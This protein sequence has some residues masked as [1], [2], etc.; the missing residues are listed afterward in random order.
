MSRR[1]S[2]ASV[3][4]LL[5]IACCVQAQTTTQK[6]ATASISGKVTIKG[7][8]AVGVVIMATPADDYRRPSVQKPH[9]ARTDQT[10]RYRIT[11]LPA[12]SYTITPVAP[13]LVLVQQSESVVLSEGEEVEDINL[14]LA[15]GGV[16]TG[17]V[18]DAEGEPLM[19]VGV[20]LTPLSEKIVR[21]DQ[22]LARL[23]AGN[24][25]DD[26]GIYRAF[27]LP[28][29]K[30]KVSV[31]ESRSGRTWSRPYY[32]ETFFP[33]VTDAAKATVIEVTEGS[34][35][36]NVDIV[37]GRPVRTFKVAGRVIDGDT[38]KPIPG[39]NYSVGHRTVDENGGSFST[40]SSSGDR[41]SANGEFHVE[42][43]TPGKYTIFTGVPAG[44]ELTSGSV[45]VDVVDRDV[46]NLVITMTK[47]G[48]LSG[49]VALDGDQ[50]ARAKLGSVSICATVQR[51]NS[52]FSNTAQSSI[53]QDGSFRINGVRS[54]LAMFWLCSGHDQREQFQ[55]VR[56]ER[57]GVAQPENFQVGEGEQVTG[58]RV[59]LKHV[60]LTGA[61]RGQVKV[62]IGELPPISRLWLD[63]WPLDENLQPQPQSSFPSPKLDARGHFLAEGLPAGTYRLTIAVFSTASNRATQTTQQVIVNDDAVTEVTVIIKPDP[64]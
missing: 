15:P 50:S 9:R 53:A 59:L 46:T 44:S 11:D 52:E 20:K 16:I 25:T 36:T 48:S 14:Q 27:G 64:K 6:I 54:G 31:G 10:G 40:S 22:T 41:T 28:A 49:V 32:K 8:P 57:N 13:A 62:E 12:G 34:E 18:T 33:S 47:G 58:F 29:G 19:G 5:S 30:Y 60:K 38:G 55:I 17:R 2:T 24:E 63:L 21:S 35:T 39:L 37:M 45:T 4:L 3:L 23:H 61:I 7:K 42:N 1:Q 56:V 43:L 51:K 26:R